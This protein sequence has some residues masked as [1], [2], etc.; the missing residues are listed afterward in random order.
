MP[1]SPTTVSL[2]GADA[3]KLTADVW[4]PE[5]AA[6]VL[7]LHGGGQTRHSWKA[8]SH[9][10]AEAGLRVVALDLR[11]HGDSDWSPD[12]DYGIDRHCAD[13]LEVLGQLDT[14]V[15]IIGASLGALT[16]LLVS[17]TAGGRVNRL[18]L[19]DMVPRF[20][21]AGSARI[22]AFMQGAPDGFG[23]LEEAAQAIAAYLPHRRR[24]F[25]PDGLRRNLRLREN[26]R[27]YWHW[28][29]RMWSMP[30]KETPEERAVRFESAAR[31]LGIPVLLLH[32]ALSDVVSAEGVATFR[33]QVPHLEVVRLPA[34]A[35]TAAGDDNDAF[36]TAVVEFCTR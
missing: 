35:H 6:T 29:P 13:V 14:P 23:S 2:R 7:M 16:G 33:T 4:G 26:G 31:S 28:D 5:D 21:K 25:N 18:A 17:E 15:T 19:V 8:T 1:I 12:G 34:A 20:E 24:A 9:I 3:L 32:G 22:R 36:T 30:P 10:L 11:G 27:W